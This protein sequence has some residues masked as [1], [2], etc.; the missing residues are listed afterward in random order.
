MC[1]KTSL[2]EGAP[3]SGPLMARHSS[4]LIVQ[5]RL[6]RSAFAF[7]SSL[8]LGFT[9]TAS[10]W[11]PG[12]PWEPRRPYG[13]YAYPSNEATQGISS[14]RSVA[15]EKEGGKMWRT[16]V[17]VGD[18]VPADPALLQILPNA[19]LPQRLPQRRLDRDLP[20]IV[21]TPELAV[22]GV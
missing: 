3:P 9:K 15:R 6:L 10:S 1:L 18:N 19:L 16:E 14:V 4:R 17:V 5:A 8:G 7:A 20:T 11:N 22:A 12:Q 21:P 13:L 2:A